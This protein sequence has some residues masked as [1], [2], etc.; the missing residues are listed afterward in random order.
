MSKL[1]PFI[2]TLNLGKAFSKILSEKLEESVT[3]ILSEWVN[4]KQSKRKS[5]V[6]FLKK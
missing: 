4:L 6:N 3:E 5:F 1:N 2:Q